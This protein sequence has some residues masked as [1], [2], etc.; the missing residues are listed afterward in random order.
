MIITVATTKSGVGKSTI[1]MN[2][3]LGSAKVEFSTA[4]VYR[5]TKELY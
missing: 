2:L 5:R 1:T 3:A 4:L